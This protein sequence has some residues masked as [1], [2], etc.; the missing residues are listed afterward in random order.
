MFFEGRIPLGINYGV[1]GGPRWK[2]TP[3]VDGRGREQ[4]ISHWSQ[5]LHSYSFD[6]GESKPLNRAE[7]LQI[8][9]FF[10][11]RKGR[12]EGFRY[13]DWADWQTGWQALGVANGSLNTFQILK[14]YNWGTGYCYR[15]IHK[16]VASSVRVRLDQTE[17]FSGWQ[18]DPTDGRLIFEI[19]P[20]P[21]VQV[22]CTC[23]FDVPVRFKSDSLAVRY[24]ANGFY[25]LGV[26][27]LE[28]YRVNGRA[29]VPLAEV[30][31][32]IGQQLNLGHDLGTSGGPAYSTTVNDAGQGFELRTQNYPTP[33]RLW[34]VNSRRCNR[35]ELDSLLAAF[36]VC[37][38]AATSFLY[39]DHPS[40]S[41]ARV[42]FEQDS[43]RFRFAAAVGQK[44]F[45][46]HQGFDLIECL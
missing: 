43:L 2:T 21:G 17:I 38:G 41:W 28:E 1:V 8:S 44:V 37:R 3:L 12:L 26:I 14:L 22:W 11:A 45:F 5:P 4:R 33:R 16:P 19:P 32:Y 23:A 9:N 13:R 35:A 39:Y 46:D 40:Q 36:W 18:V 34:S 20:P 10:N 29:V 27:E 42:R 31:A 7:Y 30:P 25:G 24:L 15:T 6:R